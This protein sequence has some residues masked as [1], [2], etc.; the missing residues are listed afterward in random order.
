LEFLSRVIKITNNVQRSGL[1]VVFPV[2][3]NVAETTLDAEGREC[4]DAIIGQLAGYGWSIL[5]CSNVLV[6][7]EP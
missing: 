6:T 7:I 1:V 4:N 2:R 5:L 3:F